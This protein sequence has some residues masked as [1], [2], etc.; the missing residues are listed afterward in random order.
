MKANVY[1]KDG[2]GFQIIIAIGP[3]SPKVGWIE[4]GDKR[5]KLDFAT[6]V[7]LRLYLRLSFKETIEVSE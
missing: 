5:D 3:N 2:C 6:A 4:C 1:S 7:A